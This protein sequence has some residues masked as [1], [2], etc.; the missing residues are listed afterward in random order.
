[1]KTRLIVCIETPDKMEVFREEGES[2]EDYVG[3]EKELEEFRKEYVKD[4]HDDVIKTFKHLFIEEEGYFEE[5][6]LDNVEEV[7]IEGC[8]SFE[9]YGIKVTIEDA[10]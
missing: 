4:L 8:E 3:K 7:S 1:M 5:M 9:D 6:W 10:K 2:D